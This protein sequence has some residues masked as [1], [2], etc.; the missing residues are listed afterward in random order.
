MEFLLIARV[1]K[2]ILGNKV[3]KVKGNSQDNCFSV[4]LHLEVDML[5]R[6]TQMSE[7]GLGIKCY[8][9]RKWD[10]RSDGGMDL[11]KCDIRYMFLVC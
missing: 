5:G 6:Y 8:K 1:N 9:K 2:P 3:I 10:V 7:K 4:E 11:Q